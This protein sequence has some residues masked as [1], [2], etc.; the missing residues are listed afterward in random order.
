MERMPRRSGSYWSSNNISWL[1]QQVL[2]RLTEEI[3][4]LLVFISSDRFGG[5]VQRRHLHAMITKYM[6]ELLDDIRHLTGA[7]FQGELDPNKCE[8]LDIVESCVWALSIL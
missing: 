6:Q 4:N 7:G 1:G 3:C 2:I 8:E 5:T